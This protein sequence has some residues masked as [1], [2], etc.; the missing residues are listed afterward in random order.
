MIEGE[1]S[2]S[3]YLAV[4][5]R[6]WRVVALAMVMTLLG[7][8][9]YSLLQP[10]SYEARTKLMAQPQKY[11]WRLDV[12]FQTVVDDL[13]IDRRTD[14]MVLLTER[15]PGVALARQVIEKLG[16]RLPADMR[17]PEALWKQI[18]AR[19]N[20]SDSS[21][22]IELQASAPSAELAQ[23]L[24][25]TW[26]AV[27]T[28]EVDLRFGQSGDRTKFEAE[29]AQAQGRLTAAAAALEAF[30][31]R[32]GMALELGNQL[33]PL[34]EGAVAAGMT[35]QQQ[36][37]VLQSGAVAEYQVALDRI[38]IVKASIEQTGG[39]GDHNVDVPF[40]LLTVPVLTQRGQFTAERLA[41]LRTN[42]DQLRQ[43]LEREE[44]ALTTTV[45][46]LTRETNALQAVLASQIRER[47]V[48]QRENALADEVVRAL[49]RKITEIGIEQNVG[50]APLVVLDPARLPAAPAT[51]RWQINIGAALVLGAMGGILLAF[52]VDL[53]R[54]KTA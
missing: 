18:S 52:A 23:T 51:P 34:K 26:A 49:Q 30:E 19:L 15:T 21:R 1:F 41:V 17:R 14:Y 44:K 43:A 45:E 33:A 27:W 47:N 39:E 13:R 53:V 6:R 3:Q 29:L 16:D 46:S 31:A 48:L 28:N 36:Q 2:L 9:V 37:F 24:V 10:V 50:G 32:T 7:A 54:R 11:T 4:L 20:K 40:D 38:R 8:V 12:S 35:E 25:N 5:R 42:P 22:L